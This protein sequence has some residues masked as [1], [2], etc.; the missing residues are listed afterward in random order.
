MSRIKW[1]V[2]LF[3]IIG[4]L[5]LLIN[6][7]VW[8]CKCEELIAKISSVLHLSYMHSLCNV[9]LW[10]LLLIG[11][12][13][14]L[15]SGIWSGLVICLTNGRPWSVGVPA[16]REPCILPHFLCETSQTFWLKMGD[17]M[18]E[19]SLAL[20]KVILKYPRAKHV[21]EAGLG[22]QSCQPSQ[23]LFTP[24]ETGVKPSKTRTA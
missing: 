15:H 24:V 12:V 16:L 8:F 23:L 22:Q 2:Y 1:K 19:N 9:L 6:R 18:D 13:L 17:N 5:D 20:A 10:Q 3:R 11:G 21:R 14:F 4:K 7:I